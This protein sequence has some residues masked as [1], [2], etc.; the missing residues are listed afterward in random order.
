MGLLLEAPLPPLDSFKAPNLEL[1]REEQ[2]YAALIDEMP[3]RAV[4]GKDRVVHLLD[5]YLCRFH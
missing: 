1:Q 5:I 4:A 3:Y 2:S